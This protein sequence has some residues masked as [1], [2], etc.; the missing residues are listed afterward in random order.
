MQ[1][2]HVSSSNQKALG[3]AN[4]IKQQFDLETIQVSLESAAR[5]RCE[6]SAARSQARVALGAWEALASPSRGVE[7]Q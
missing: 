3:F 4:G 6:A 5:R 7:M 2:G 1:G